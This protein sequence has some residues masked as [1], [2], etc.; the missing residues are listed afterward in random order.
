MGAEIGIVLEELQVE[1]LRGVHI[2]G[3]ANDMADW[4]S[5]PEKWLSPRPPALK[6]VKI[7]STERRSVDFYVLP[8]PRSSPSLWGQTEEAPLHNAWEALR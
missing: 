3:V 4:L 8:S 2:P 5:R 7:L 6:D 1:K